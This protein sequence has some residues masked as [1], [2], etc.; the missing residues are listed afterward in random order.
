MAQRALMRGC[1]SPAKVSIAPV[2]VKT[3]VAPATPFS[4]AWSLWE[5]RPVT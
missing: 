4:Y 2:S 1:T 5:V 3:T